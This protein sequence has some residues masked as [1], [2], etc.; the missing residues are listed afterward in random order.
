M[1][2]CEEIRR[3]R[4]ETSLRDPGSLCVFVEVG[5]EVDSR[6]RRTGHQLHNPSPS[7]LGDS[8][9][10]PI[11]YDEG[12]NVSDKDQNNKR[13]QKEKEG[14]PGGGDEVSGGGSVSKSQQSSSQ[15]VPGGSFYPPRHDVDN[16]GVKRR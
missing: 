15:G 11:P 3:I 14:T 7:S 5:G 9:G 1:V 6:R 12:F 13:N 10:P 8:G 4:S 2:V 16:S